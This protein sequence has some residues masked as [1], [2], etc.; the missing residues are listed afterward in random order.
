MTEHFSLTFNQFKFTFELSADMVI[1]QSDRNIRI[2]KKET[3]GLQTGELKLY[4][5]LVTTDYQQNHYQHLFG[6]IILPV[7][8]EPRKKELDQF[9]QHTVLPQLMHF[10]QGL[11]ENKLCPWIP[12][13]FTQA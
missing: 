10:F 8:Q 4:N 7:K 3:K 12:H 6:H 2:G 1:W 9:L 5:L 13:Q 11:T